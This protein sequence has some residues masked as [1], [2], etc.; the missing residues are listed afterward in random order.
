[1]GPFTLLPCNP[2]LA[3]TPLD[4]FLHTDIRPRPTR[5][6]RVKY[7][8]RNH[9]YPDTRTTAPHRDA[10]QGHHHHSAHPARMKKNRP[11]NP[12]NAPNMCCTRWRPRFLLSLLF[13]FPFWGEARRLA[14]NCTGPFLF[15]FFPP[16]HRYPA[17][18]YIKVKAGGWLWQMASKVYVEGLREPLER[19]VMGWMAP[20][21]RCRLFLLR[22]LSGPLLLFF[23]FSPLTISLFFSSSL[24]P[25]GMHAG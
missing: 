19:E 24:V 25:A 7:K 1:M 8:Q 14:L 15:A 17:A 22:G 20:L 11:P 2:N 12:I 9:Q 5:L 3:E 16:S 6:G 4:P 18:A 21:G 10:H 13:I 23:C